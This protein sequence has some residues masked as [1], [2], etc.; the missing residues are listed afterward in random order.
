[1]P[2]LISVET[3]CGPIAEIDWNRDHSGVPLVAP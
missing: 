2:Q 1:M 3:L